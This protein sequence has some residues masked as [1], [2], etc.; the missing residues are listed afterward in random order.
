MLAKRKKV[1]ALSL[2][3]ILTLFISSNSV[4]APMLS[5][6]VGE[7]GSS[8]N[9]VN[10]TSVPVDRTNLTTTVNPE[11][12]SVD[13]G[14]SSATYLTRRITLSSVVVDAP[15]EP[16]TATCEYQS[17][18]DYNI[19]TTWVDENNNTITEV[20]PVRIRV[21]NT[22]KN[23]TGI[24]YQVLDNA[25]FK[26]RLT[27]NA[28]S[29]Y[30][31][32]ILSP[33]AYGSHAS[34]INAISDSQKDYKYSYDGLHLVTVEISNGNLTTKVRRII[35]FNA[36]AVGV[37]PSS[38]YCAGNS[39]KIKIYMDDEDSGNNNR[40]WGWKGAT[41]SGS[42]TELVFCRV[43]GRRFKNISPSRGL[44]ATYA[45]L[46]LGKQ[47]PSGSYPYWRRIDNEGTR[48]SNHQTG[49]I[50]PN[51]SNYAQGET[52]LQLCVFP[53]GYPTSN[54]RWPSLGFGYGVLTTPYTSST[55]IAAKGYVFTDDE[56]QANQNTYGGYYYGL[57]YGRYIISGSYDS[58]FNMGYVRF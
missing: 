5:W 40:Y 28:P 51:I 47:C 32:K 16:G 6:V 11:S 17:D 48:N 36:I 25:N 41:Y 19:T 53:G 24:S 3:G 13:C 34:L 54:G 12:Y 10:S 26:V 8:D 21:S 15:P 55:F 14:S 45:V 22:I 35:N 31:C 44:G 56:D 29:G 37:I 57:Y 20:A 33:T 18:G 49:N 23:A 39:E 9:E 52:V 30:T 2:T 27:C 42:N 4:A 1:V 46:R 43:D 50:S 7:T 38:G 58:Q